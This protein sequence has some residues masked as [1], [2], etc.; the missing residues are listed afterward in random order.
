MK[1]KEMGGLFDGGTQPQKDGC[2]DPISPSRFCPTWHFLGS[3]ISPVAG[4]GC[5]KPLVI[6]V[7][8]KVSGSGRFR[9][10]DAVEDPKP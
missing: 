3:I 5:N 4:K 10:M 2:G 7:S 9:S 8:L 6:G 1:I